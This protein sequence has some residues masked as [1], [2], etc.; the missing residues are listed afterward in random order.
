M[1]RVRLAWSSQELR[2]TADAMPIGMPMASA[3]ARA[4]RDS[5]TVGPTCCQIVRVTG[6]RL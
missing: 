4:M 6:S 5:I 3:T 1:T 2:Y